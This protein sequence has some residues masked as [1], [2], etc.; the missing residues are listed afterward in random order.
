MSQPTC[1]DIPPAFS[2]RTQETTG[3]VHVSNLN[4]AI[5]ADSALPAHEVTAMSLDLFN[6]GQRDGSQGRVD[7]MSMD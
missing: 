6:Y 7:S 4:E 5:K 2:G 1:S 3:F